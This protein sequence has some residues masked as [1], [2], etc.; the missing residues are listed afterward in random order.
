[1]KI[2]TTL[3]LLFGWAIGQAQNTEDN[4]TYQSIIDAEHIMVQLSTVDQATMMSML[5]Q[6]FYVY[7]DVK[8]KKKKNVS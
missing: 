8:G 3:L 2:Y 7:F 5:H 6:G 1:M 4:I